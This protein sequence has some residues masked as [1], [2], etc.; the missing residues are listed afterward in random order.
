VPAPKLEQALI[1]RLTGLFKAQSKSR[2]AYQEVQIMPRL[3]DVKLSGSRI[4]LVVQPD[5]RTPPEAI[6]NFYEFQQ[7]KNNVLILSGNDSHLANEV[8]ARLRELYA[9][10]KIQANL[11]PSDSLFD[12]A[13]D[14]LEEL[15]ERFTKAVSGAYNGSSFLVPVGAAKASW[16]WLPSTTASVSV[17]ASTPP[18]RRSRNC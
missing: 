14:K 10:E 17:T 13:R 7:E 6:R 12:E 8:E 15:E 1:N 16:S 4:L 5:G 3:D 2:A 18:R 9:I 11:K